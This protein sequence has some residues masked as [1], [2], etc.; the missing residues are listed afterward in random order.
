MQT[1]HNKVNNSFRDS[2]PISRVLLLE[3]FSSK[4]LS[5]DLILVVLLWK[6]GP[7]NG[8][9]E[10]SVAVPACT[11]LLDCLPERPV[12]SPLNQQLGED[13]SPCLTASNK[14]ELF[15]MSSRMRDGE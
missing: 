14:Y 1:L 15:L 12:E 8:K 6:V 5:Q 7:R 2:H 10:E 9:S 11:T 13:P 4:H 3:E